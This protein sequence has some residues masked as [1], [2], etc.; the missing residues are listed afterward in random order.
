MTTLLSKRAL[1]AGLGVGGLALLAQRASADTP[2]TSF[3]FPVTGGTTARTLPDRLAE[4]RSVKDFGAVG[5]GSHDDSDAIQAA[6]DWTVEGD[7]GIVYFP[8]GR[9]KITRPISLE[10]GSGELNQ[11]GIH[12]QVQLIG[13]GS[14]GSR[15]SGAV[16][17]GNFPDYLFK[18]ASGKQSV[19]MR[20]FDGLTL[21]NFNTAGGA[22][23]LNGAMHSLVRNCFIQAHRGVISE[24]MNAPNIVE[25][26][27]F[28]WSNQAADGSIGVMLAGTGGTCI[29]T[30]IVGYDNAIRIMGPGNVVLGCRMEVNNIAINIGTDQNGSVY[31]A[32]GFQITS[33]SFEANA[34]AI[35]CNGATG[36]LVSGLLIQ[37][38]T[39]ATKGISQY[40]VYM[41][42][43]TFTSFIGL[44]AA[45]GFVGGAIVQDPNGLAADVN[46][47]N[48]SP[49]AHL[50]TDGLTS[51]ATP[52]I[53]NIY[54]GNTG[55]TMPPWVVNGLTVTDASSGLIPARTTIT[56]HTETSITL[57]AQVTGTMGN[58]TEL[59]LT[60]DRGIQVGAFVLPYPVGIDISRSNNAFPIT[61]ITANRSLDGS[62]FLDIEL[63][64]HSPIT[65]TI[66]NDASFGVYLPGLGATYRITQTG[67]GTASVVAGSA[68]VSFTAGA[69]A[70]AGQWGVL[71][72]RKIGINHWVVWRG[73]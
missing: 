49:A 5:D 27:S 59:I 1:S 32:S 73:T 8:I 20:V 42:G 64:S 30:D 31:G 17:E 62:C 61:V 65:L 36:G 51:P 3:A 41:H 11:G 13:A 71:F 2:L 10:N 15:F 33:C 53:V 14:N 54:F 35:Y 34:C 45:A 70:S 72:L 38:T 4:V 48:C 39:G 52:Q 24:T 69:N 47:T 19:S 22:I 29:G 28:N 46:F 21:R 55:F 25:N 37:G 23:Y 26:C 56:S 44:M 57:S 16:I 50:S 9:Y 58:H 68:T 43:C 7:R 40:A 6:I 63:H 18:R 66:N 12:E 60:N 67:T